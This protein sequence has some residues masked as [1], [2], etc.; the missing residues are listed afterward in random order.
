MLAYFTQTQWGWK[1]KMKI[2]VRDY[3]WACIVVALCIALFLMWR[4]EQQSKQLL[5]AVI[6]QNE[7]L[8]LKAEQDGMLKAELNALRGELRGIKA[9]EVDQ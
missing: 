2:S 7:Q 6:L 4:R 9:K 1:A 8:V 3:L 5:Q